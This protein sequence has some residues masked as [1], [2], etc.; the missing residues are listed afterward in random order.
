MLAPNTKAP[1][2]SLKDQEGNLVELSSFLGKKTIVLFF[3]PQDE[4]PGCTAEAC[5]FR[6]NYI[7]F[8]AH[9]A[10]VFG[11]SSDSVESHQA[12]RKK[13]QL[14]YPLLSDPTGE[15]A[16]SYG[17]KRRFGFL[18]DRVSFVIDPQG[19]IRHVVSSQFQI[20]RHIDECLRVVQRNTRNII[21]N[22]PISEEKPA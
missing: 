3:Y 5:S 14:P 22:N 16:L 19:I 11:I 1:L 2:F 13:H 8:T 20:H 4:T 7:G 6:D 9:Q 15:V 21:A 12:F 17:V 10:Q 18:K